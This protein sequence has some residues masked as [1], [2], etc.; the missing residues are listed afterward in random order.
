[1]ENKFL[2]LL[3]ISLIMAIVAISGA[4]AQLAISSQTN[5]TNYNANATGTFVLANSNLTTNI[6]GII[7][8]ITGQLTPAGA[9]CPATLNANTNN[10]VSY[11]V[12]VPQGT[13]PGSYT[14]TITATGTLGGSATTDSKTFV[15]TVP[16]TPSLSLSWISAPSDIYSSGNATAVINIT[17][18]GNINLNV[19]LSARFVNSSYNE[20]PFNLAAGASTTR[21][22][23]L[24]SSRAIIG[25][26]AFSVQAQGANGAYSTTSSLDKSLNVN[27]QYCVANSSNSNIYIEDIT[28]QDDIRDKDFN[29]LDT[30]DVKVKVRNSYSTSKYVIVKAVLV[31]N[32]I[33]DG[34]EEKLTQKISDANTKT[35]TLNM[36]I[37]A[38]VS[39]G[40]Y[41]L[42]IKAYE[43]GKSTE[44]EQRSIRFYVEKDDHSIILKNVE[45]TSPVECNGLLEVKGILYNLGES[46]EDQVKFTYNDDLKFNDSVI[47]DGFDS[48]DQKDFS[49]SFT[50]P[51]NA[52][53][54]LNKLVLKT[55]FD[56][57]EDDDSYDLT[58]T[59]NYYYTVSGNCLK[60]TNNVSLMSTEQTVFVAKDT[61]VSIAITNT[62]N[63]QQTYSVT[64]TSNDFLIKSISPSSMVLPAGSTSYAVIKLSPKEN[65]TSGSHDV[66]VGI[67]YAG[68]TETKVISLNVQQS[69]IVVTKWYNAAKDFI[70]KNYLLIFNVAFGLLIIYLIVKLVRMPKK[71]PTVEQVYKSNIKKNF[72]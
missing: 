32:S 64:A 35:F 33:V 57:N 72:K 52:T 40:E 16:T 14:E 19:N 42:F 15:V 1:M 47:Y 17:N 51:Q 30:F 10:I 24:S 67:N 61:D 29:P 56:Y 21:S 7:C 48:G 25:Q 31:R 71:A 46:D 37:P 41:Q 18:I 28:T 8:T 2:V 22:I 23:T 5:S 3:S 49:F 44:C 9:T 39:R 63:T 36:Q 27:Y 20:T 68:K 34:T 13:Q 60:Q 45:L 12:A 69:S 59:Y 66:S 26:N 6:T 50:I 62:G 4:F 11:W 65:I 43:E 54:K 58:E 38:D 53:E 55:F 70:K